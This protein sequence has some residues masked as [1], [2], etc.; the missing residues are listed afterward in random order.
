MRKFLVV[1]GSD[2]VGAAINKVK[3]EKIDYFTFE[4]VDFT[5]ETDKPVEENLSI[6]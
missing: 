4:N 3:C 6:S 1:G 2:F 5:L